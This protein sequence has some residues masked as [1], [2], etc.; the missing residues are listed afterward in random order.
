[1]AS[2]HAMFLTDTHGI[3]PHINAHAQERFGLAG[4]SSRSHEAG[5]L[6]VGES[7]TGK[8]H[9]DSSIQQTKSRKDPFLPVDCSPSPLRCSKA[10]CL[11]MRAPLLPS[12]LS[13]AL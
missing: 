4:Q 1:M 9:L 3:M 5:Q 10:R 8:S 6:A 12:P 7:G 2:T 13:A 11:A